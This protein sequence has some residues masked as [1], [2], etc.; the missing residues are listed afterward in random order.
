MPRYR[1]KVE[2]TVEGEDERGAASG[3]ARFVQD[4]LDEHSCIECWEPGKPQLIAEMPDPESEGY[5]HMFIFA[6][7][8]IYAADDKLDTAH[9][10]IR[11][12]GQPKSQADYGKLAAATAYIQGIQRAATGIDFQS[13]GQKARQK[14]TW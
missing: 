2:F 14:E 9:Q 8:Q 5:Q 10:I 3:L 7:G 4:S 6:S 13:E 11:E 12:V 1:I